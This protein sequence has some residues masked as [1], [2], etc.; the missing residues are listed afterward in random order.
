MPKYS[1]CCGNGKI[2]LSPIIHPPKIIF[3]LFFSG[4]H[5][6]KNFLQN[7]RS[8]NNMFSFTSM[9]ERI[10]KQVNKFPLDG[11]FITYEGNST[12]FAQLYIHD[13]ENKVANR[14]SIIRY[15]YKLF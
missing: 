13:S 3:D 14:I 6:S 10:D 8:Y 11:E 9:E 5:R 7:I 1:I 12:K 4:Y 2:K 15:D